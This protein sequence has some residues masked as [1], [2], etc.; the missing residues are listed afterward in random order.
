MIGQTPHYVEL[1]LILCGEMGPRLRQSGDSGRVQGSQD[2]A[3]SAV[4]VKPDAALGNTTLATFGG[5]QK[6]MNTHV[7]HLDEVLE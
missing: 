3:H 5:E 6:R 1:G 2:R 7:S 4:I